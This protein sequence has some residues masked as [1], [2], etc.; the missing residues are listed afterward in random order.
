MVSW[1]QSTAGANDRQMQEVYD[2]ERAVGWAAYDADDNL[3]ELEDVWEYC[4]KIMRRKTFARHYPKTHARHAAYNMKPE[5]FT[6]YGGH[7]YVQGIVQDKDSPYRNTSAGLAIK[8]TSRGGSANRDEIN[9]SKWARQKWV[10]IHELAHVVDEIE[11]GS[12]H[13]IYHQGHGW[14]WCSI[15]QRLVGMAFGHQAWK[16]LK[17]EMRAKDVK[18]LQPKTE[19]TARHPKELSDHW[20]I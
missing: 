6:P 18:Y 20:V 16:A 14:Q 2:A 17:T 19:R 15:Y 5:R 1:K 12:P 3:G 7:V 9:L 13:F 4:Y 11:N 10:V 8:P